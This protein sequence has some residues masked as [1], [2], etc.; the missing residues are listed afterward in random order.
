ML[1]QRPPGSSVTRTRS[2][3]RHAS[4]SGTPAGSFLGHST[5]SE[6]STRVRCPRRKSRPRKVRSRRPRLQAEKLRRHAGLRDGHLAPSPPSRRLASSAG[7]PRRA[8]AGRTGRGASWTMQ[9][10]AP[11]RRPVSGPGQT[12]RRPSVARTKPSW[13]RGRSRERGPIPP[14]CAS[15][16]LI[17]HASRPPV[18]RR[19]VAGD[20]RTDAILKRRNGAG[21]DAD[22]GRMGRVMQKITAHQQLR[23]RGCNPWSPEDRRRAVAPSS[24]RW[25]TRAPR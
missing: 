19:P 21:E 25:S 14:A 8:I 7:R 24:R 17:R 1:D 20:P 15:T 23:R 4:A 11:D 2:P 22:D 18:N 13:S 9:A 3:G 10:P 12:S 16:S 6:R 5:G